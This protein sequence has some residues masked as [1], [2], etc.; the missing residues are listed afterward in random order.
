MSQPANQMPQSKTDVTTPLR[1][2][3]AASLFDGHDAAINI[4]RRLIQAQ[5]AEVIHLG[6][7]RSVLDIVR[8]AIQEDADA[9]A[10]SSYQGGHIEFF[11]YMVDLLRERDSGHI[12]VFGGGGGTI[13]P[14]EIRELEAY[15]VERIYH[16]DDGMDMG[17]VEMIEDV[18]KRAAEHRVP[19]E[20][21]GQPDIQS[22]RSIANVI[23]ALED[24]VFSEA[25]LKLKRREWQSRP[26]QAPVVGIT[27]TGGAGKSSVTDELLN[28]FG[29]SFPDMKIAVLAVDPTRRR[30]G[31]A[32]LGDRIRMNSLRNENIPVSLVCMIFNSAG[33]GSSLL[34]TKLM[35]RTSTSAPSSILKTMST[36]LVSPGTRLSSYA[37]SARKKPSSE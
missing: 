8:A 10:I 27:G 18:V 34:P 32:L 2:V 25:E 13:T 15:G 4:M 26:A 23:S 37:T 7:N 33:A 3:T 31:G 11:K 29:Q 14:E 16:P 5:G 22:A 35:R 24:E 19:T 9:I 20:Y 36:W 12:R 21:P 17:L 1:F 30:T 6:H 28:R